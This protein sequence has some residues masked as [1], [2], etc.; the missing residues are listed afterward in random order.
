MTASKV[1]SGTTA[2]IKTTSTRFNP[3][4][5]LADLTAQY[6]KDNYLTG[7]LFTGRDGQELPPAFFEEKL[8]NAIAKLEEITHI[9]VL[10]QTVCG[11]RHDYHTNDY[12]NYAF[13]RLFRTPV[14]SVSQV[15]RELESD[16]R[17]TPDTS[18]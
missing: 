3:L 4:F 9:D 6:L 12:L 15:K 7:F 5:S 2:T 16:T 17:D 8:A 18:G 1:A 11:E 10:Q 13:M 14:T